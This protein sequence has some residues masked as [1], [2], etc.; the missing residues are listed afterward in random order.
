M[1]DECMQLQLNRR[2][3]TNKHIKNNAAILMNRKMTT[4]KKKCK[5]T[6]RFFLGQKIYTYI[7]LKR[8]KAKREY[9]EKKII[10]SL[11]PPI[12]RTY[13][14]ALLKTL[15]IRVYRHTLCVSLLCYDGT[16]FL[17]PPLCCMSCEAN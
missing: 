4:K 12:I 7:E 10:P 15:I 9:E 2:A 13:R 1:H 6:N 5:L 8:E 14:T 16:S 3:Q 17:P 11:T